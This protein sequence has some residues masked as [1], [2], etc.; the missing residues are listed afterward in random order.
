MTEFTIGALTGAVT[1]VVSVLAGYVWRSRGRVDYRARAILRAAN[2][3]IVRFRTITVCFADRTIE[4]DGRT[5]KHD[6]ECVT[7]PIL[8]SEAIFLSKGYERVS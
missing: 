6:T 7:M 3:P 1:A 4:I 2:P 5:T 8:S